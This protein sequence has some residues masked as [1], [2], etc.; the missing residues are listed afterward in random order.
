MLSKERF[1][2][3]SNLCVSLLIASF[4]SLLYYKYNIY[5]LDTYSSFING[6]TINY[7]YSKKVDYQIV[8]FFIFVGIICFI[9]CEKC[10]LSGKFYYLY[11]LKC[12]SIPPSLVKIG[13]RIFE[14]VI[15]MLM[16]YITTKL[17]FTLVGYENYSLFIRNVLIISITTLSLLFRRRA[18]LVSQ[19][20]F[21]FAPLLYLNDEYIFNGKSID[22]EGSQYL[23]YFLSLLVILILW[24][25]ILDII[26]N[27]NKIAFSSLMFLAILI[28]GS[29]SRVYILDEYH[30]GEL[31]TA[32]HQSFGLNQALYSEFIPTKGFMHILIGFINDIFYSGGYVTISL[33]AKLFSLL[34]ALLLL[35]VMVK[36]Y[37]R[38]ALVFLLLLGIPL[39]GHFRIDYYYP[40][41]I[42]LC[43]LTDKK[44]TNDSYNFVIIFLFYSFVS[45]LYYNA[46]ALAFSIALSPFLF[47]KLH[48]IYKSNK[49][50]DK[51]QLILLSVGVIVFIYSFDYILSSLGYSLLNSGSNLLYWGNPGSPI[52]IVQSNLWV[53]ITITMLYILYTKMIE[54]EFNNLIWPVFFVIFPLVILS[55]M[56]GRADGGF[57]RALGYT[58]FSS[59]LLFCY[60]LCNNINLMRSVKVVLGLLASILLISIDFYPKFVTLNNLHNFEAKAISGDMVLV[61]NDDIPNL[62]KGFINDERYND[63]S[64]EYELIAQLSEDSTFLIIDPYTTQSARYS[65]YGKKIPTI[66]HSVLNISSLDSQNIELKKVKDMNIKIIRVSSGINRYHLFH[67][68]LASLNYVLTTYNHRDYLI[69]PDLFEK[70]KGKFNLQESRLLDSEYTTVDFGLLPIKWGGAFFNE[71]DNLVKSDITLKTNYVNNITGGPQ[72]ILGDDDPYVTFVTSNPIEGAKNNLIHIDLFKSTESICSAKFYWDAGTGFNERNSVVFQLSSGDAVVP[73][74]MNLN[75]LKSDSISNVRLDIDQCSGQEV[76]IK[77]IE[78]YKFD[79]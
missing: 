34:S 12:I 47:Y 30:M 57:Y 63:L 53:L 58:I 23:T 5:S 50:P 18:L 32:Y 4:I 17:F 72:Y 11:R 55:Y 64:I 38:W 48:D 22:F 9:V 73:L 45:F 61:E 44:V 67:D 7:I 16:A 56:E 59:I 40:I 19:L 76:E 60:I 37:S 77:S 26:K 70:V 13:R 51:I 49:K 2:S 33:S 8:P 42:G 65:L 3:L 36:Y 28:I 35:G 21:S 66:S 24:L 25:T 29:A 15:V 79:Y 78:F 31:F 43:L 27:R 69:S 20:L 41:I 75:W 52:N 74:N 68:Y 54:S 46:F 39:Y 10:E 6:D 1:F 62:G 71:K 14:V